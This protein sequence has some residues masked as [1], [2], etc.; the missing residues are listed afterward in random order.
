MKGRQEV[1]EKFNEQ[2]NMSADELKKWLDSPECHKAGTGVGIESGK[3]IVD[4]L[5]HNPSKDPSRYSDVGT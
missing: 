5:S 1:I 4:I 2:V 3:K